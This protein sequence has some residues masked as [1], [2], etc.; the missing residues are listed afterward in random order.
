MPWQILL[1][2]FGIKSF[3]GNFTW[4]NLLEKIGAIHRGYSMN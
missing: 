1:G 3:L 4:T 2:F